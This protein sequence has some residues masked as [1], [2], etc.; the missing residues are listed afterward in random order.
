MQKTQHIL[1][2]FFPNLYASSC[3]K[4]TSSLL[5]MYVCTITA[6]KELADEIQLLKYH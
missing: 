3:I 6:L 1:E 2:L 5:N 4:M